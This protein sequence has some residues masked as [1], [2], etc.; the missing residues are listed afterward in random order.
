MSSLT[1]GKL[2]DYLIEFKKVVG[3]DM[4]VYIDMG[5]DIARYVYG[6]LVRENI[7]YDEPHYSDDADSEEITGQ[8]GIVLTHEYDENCPSLSAAMPICYLLSN[9]IVLREKYGNDMGVFILHIDGTLFSTFALSV[10]PC[11]WDK[12]ISTKGMAIYNWGSP[13]RVGIPGVLIE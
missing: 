10:K 6:T 3:D 5:N 11:G 8:P 4:S 13:N 2:I 12:N 7:H 9:L 1:L